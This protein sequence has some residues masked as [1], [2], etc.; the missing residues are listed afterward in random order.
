MAH[1]PLSNRQIPVA[2]YAFLST[3]GRCTSHGIAIG[4]EQRLTRNRNNWT[5]RSVQAMTVTATQAT[6][7]QGTLQRPIMARHNTAVQQLLGW[8]PCGDYRALNS[9]TTPDG[10][11]LPHLADFA[12]NLHG[13][14]IF[15][16]LDLAHAYCHIPMRLQDIAKN[17]ITTPFGLFEFLKMLFV[18]RNAAH[19]F[20]RFIDTVTRGIEDCFVY[21]DDILLA[22]ALE[23]EH[24]VLLKKMLQRLKAHGIQ[25]NKDKCILAVRRSFFW[26]TPSMLTAFDRYRKKSKQSRPSRHPKPDVNSADSSAWR[27]LLHITTTLALLDAIAS[28]AASTKITLTHDQLQAFSA[29]K[30]ALANATMQH[31]PHPT[32]EYALMVDASDHAIGAVLQQPAK[33]SWRPLAFFSNRLTATHKE[34]NHW[35][36]LTTLKLSVSS[37]KAVA[38]QEDLQPSVEVTEAAVATVMTQNEVAELAEVVRQLKELLMTNIP[39]AAKIK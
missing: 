11:P 30:D 5:T 8:P 38:D 33:N 10:Y 18:L 25:V 31:H 9:C 37:V 20:E 4:T 27:F 26:A 6:G 12:H 23:K 29:A 13:K 15:S 19:N 28:A 7:S 16:K 24:L 39:A 36:E 34:S 35:R 3:S 1:S 2:A 32:A 17:A 14:H 21:V 22:S